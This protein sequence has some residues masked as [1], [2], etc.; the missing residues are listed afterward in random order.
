MTAHP[1]FSFPLDETT[2]ASLD[3]TEANPY[4]SEVDLTNTAAFHGH[5][6]AALSRIG[7]KVGIGGY[8]EN[9]VIYRRSSHFQALEEARSVHLGTDV[10]VEALTPIFAP[11]DGVVHSFQFNDHFGDYGPTIIL[12]HS[13]DEKLPHLPTFYP[14]LY[15]LYGHLSLSSLTDLT[16]GKQIKRGDVIAWVGDFPE[17]G[18]WPP[19]L[20]FQVLTDML[21][22]WGDF[23]GVCAQKEVAFYQTICLNPL[24][25]LRS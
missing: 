22:N 8:F 9:R 12:E 18:D 20:H 5:L 13:F 25:F 4:W 7:K 19:H 3:F 2:C 1:L 16:V 23:P 21:G 10:W 6:Q 14:T 24:D 11:F 17:N 15:T